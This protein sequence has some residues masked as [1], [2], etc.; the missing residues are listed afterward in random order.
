MESKINLRSLWD[1]LYMFGLRLDQSRHV[2][3]HLAY[4][5]LSVGNIALGGR[6]KTPFVIYFVEQL[7]GRGFDPVVLMRGYGR[8]HDRPVA[9]SSESLLSELDVESLGDEALEI[10]L[11]VRPHLLI[12]S[13]RRR[14]AEDFL[15]RSPKKKYVF[16]LD[17]G[18]Q[19]WALHRDC[20]VVLTKKSDLSD[21]L[22][23]LGSLRESPE[24]LARADLVLEEGRDYLR[25]PQVSVDIGLEGWSHAALLT[26]RA[27]DPRYRRYFEKLGVRYFLN[28]SDHAT[29]DEIEAALSRTPARTLLV[30]GKE[31]VKL[32][33][34]VESE[35]LFRSGHCSFRSRLGK[36][37]DVVMVHLHLDVVHPDKLLDQVEKCLQ[38]A[39]GL[40]S[41]ELSTKDFSSKES[42]T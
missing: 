19:H 42:E 5:V 27:P 2:P 12:H 24:A 1:R 28:L 7:R 13:H 17:D 9:V 10:F 22:V 16:I 29:R 36:E 34:S 40:L 39:E 6:G 23:P 8:G 26:T 15:S 30:G 3:R 37:F 25:R 4:P 14:M 31:A 33:S 35:S 41:K 11:K 18:F 38:R 20:D 32:G 21:H